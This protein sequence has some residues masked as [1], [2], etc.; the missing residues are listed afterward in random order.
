MPFNS[1]L[2]FGFLEEIGKYFEF[3][4]TIELLANPPDE[5]NADPVDLASW[6]QRIAE[7]V[8]ANEFN[9]QYE[10]DTELTNLVRSAND[11][12]FSITPCTAGLFTFIVPGTLVSVS[13]NGT[14]LPKIWR[15]GKQ[16]PFQCSPFTMD[17]S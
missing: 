12:H 3:Q 5:Y 14:S 7:R 10:F 11:G 8:D 16:G 2:A 1:T 15:L 4:S 9:S 13:E 17:D 6:F